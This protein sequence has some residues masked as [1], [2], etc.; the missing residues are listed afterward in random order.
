LFPS[1]SLSP[2]PHSLTFSSAPLSTLPGTKSAGAFSIKGLPPETPIF[3][4]RGLTT[5]TTSDEAVARPGGAEVFLIFLEERAEPVSR[6]LS[7]VEDIFL[8]LILPFR[9]RTLPFL[10]RATNCFPFSLGVALELEGRSGTATL[11]LRP[12][13]SVLVL[14]YI[15]RFLLLF[16]RAVSG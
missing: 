13:E 10:S 16:L 14:V 8:P 5:S 4:T 15:K 7:I 2:L 12:S 11:C 1:H 9:S 3:L 6:M